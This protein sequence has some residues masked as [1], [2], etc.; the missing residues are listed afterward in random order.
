[1]SDRWESARAEHRSAVAEFLDVLRAVPDDR[2]H[3]PP[4]PGKWTPAAVALHVTVSY[5]LAGD[6]SAGPPTMRLRVS[7]RWAWALGHLLLPVMLATG[8]FPGGA[9]APREV[10]PDMGEVAALSRSDLMSRFERAASAAADSLQLLSRDPS[11]RLTHAYFGPLR[12]L[13]G[14]R[15][16]SAH[17]RHHLRGL[18]RSLRGAGEPG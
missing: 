12:P 4:A 9:K 6:T 2:W 14:L 7:K 1:M 13:Q 10:V 17:T 8:R 15:L 11:L 5:E 18:V 3:R 16:L